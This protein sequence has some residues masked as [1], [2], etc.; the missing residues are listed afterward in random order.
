M[1]IR[2][3]RSVNCCVGDFWVLGLTSSR[4][5]TAS[6]VAERHELIAGP[7]DGEDAELLDVVAERRRHAD[8]Q[9]EAPPRTAA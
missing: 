5:P 1:K 9:A 4:S 8:L 6:A 3:K 2:S 7:A